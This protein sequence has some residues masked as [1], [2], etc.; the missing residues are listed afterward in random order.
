MRVAV[1]EDITPTS[2]LTSQLPEG[3]SVAVGLPADPAALPDALADVTVA[4]VTSRIPLTRPVLERATAL[5]VVGKLGTGLDN[6]DLATAEAADIT[7]TYTPGHNALSVAEHTLC[8]LLAAARRLTEARSL[9][10]RGRWRDEATLGTQLSGK[11]VGIV[12]FG[13][14]GRR[15]GILLSGFAVDVLVHDP[16]I[17]ETDAELVDGEVT[18]FQDL[19]AGSDAVVVTAALT[20][21]TRGMFDRS[22]FDRMRDSAVLVNTARGPIVDEAALI[23][24]LREGAIAGAGLDVHAEEPLTADSPLLALDNV[25]LTPHVA[26]MTTESRAAT[27]DR[28]VENVTTVLQGRSLPARYLATGG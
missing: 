27:I 10:E 16:Y 18:G 1:D 17:P 4:F 26:A 23:A 3:W 5:E 20:E 11:T 2:R 6:V 22:A 8:L 13:D 9:I 7:V 28:L 19:L 24:A 21:E 15:V 14:V 25:V 12:G